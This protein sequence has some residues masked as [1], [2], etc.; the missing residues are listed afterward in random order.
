MHATTNAHGRLPAGAGFWGTVAAGLLASPADMAAGL[1]L[2]V[3]AGCCCA[4]SCAEACITGCQSAGA[5]A[6]VA[7]LLGNCVAFTAVPA[8]DAVAGA[9]A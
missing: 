7:G 8:A 5:A 4:G 2:A 1:D 3:L 9:T 6:A